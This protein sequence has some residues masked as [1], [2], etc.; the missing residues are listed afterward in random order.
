VK[1]AWRHTC[2]A[3]IAAGLAAAPLAGSRP[4]LAPGAIGVGVAAA[5]LLVGWR[6]R[7]RARATQV[8][9]LACVALAAASAGLGLGSLRIDAIDAGA[10]RAEPGR[11]VEL[12]GVVASPTR[13]EPDGVSA[14]LHTPAGRIQLRARYPD[15]LDVG[16]EATV[17]GRLAEPQ[18]WQRPA[19]ERRGV[20]LAIEAE[21]VAPTGVRRGG[22]AGGIDALRERAESALGRGM[23]ER[24]A[25][26]ARGFVLGQDDAIDP[27]TREDFKRSGLA[28][29]LAVSGQNVILLCL[30]AWPLLALC[31]L[32]L[33]AR[34]LALLALIA[35][36]VR[37]T[38]AGPSI[39]RA[40][41]M[42]AAGLVA[43]LADRPSSRWYA[44]LLAAAVTLALNP[45]AAGD[46]GWQLSF[47]AVLGIFCWTRRLASLLDGGAARASPRRALA[48]G[49]A[50]T[51]AATIATA[52]LMALHFDSVSAS[53]LP[54][55]VLA[56]PAVAPAMWLGMLA[57]M[58]GQLPLVPVE[59]INWLNS[60]CLG[61]VAQV[62]HWLGS[63][64][65]A[66]VEVDLP[67]PL[68]L[69]A[70]SAALAGAVE[71]GLAA[72]RRRAGFARR[73][74]PGPRRRILA[75]AAAAA[76][77]ALAAVAAAGPGGD[78]PGAS[79]EDRLRVVVLDVGQGDSILL[80][81][82]AGAPLLVDTGPSG[83][84]AARRLR[85]LGVDGLG[86]LVV[87]H[88]QSD[89]A[90]AAAEVLASVPA[91]RLALAAPS[92]PLAALAARHGV[93]P[94]PL[95]EGG[96]IRSGELRLSVLWP[97][98]ELAAPERRSGEGDPNHLSLV[99]LA[100]WRHFSM[101]LTG[102]AEAAAA[103]VD[104]GPVD[105][106]KVA[107]HG[108][109]DDGLAGLLDGTA[110]KLAVVSVGENSYGHPA[111]ETL[112]ALSEQDV[113]VARTDADGELVIEA[114]ATGWS[115]DAG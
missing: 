101:L 61:Y 32:T 82:P 104:P 65:W 105:V 52:P 28:H 59:P 110:P 85:E 71:L 108:S 114:D 57:G 2:L 33:R 16:A 19:L 60:L 76:V 113:P 107:H 41:V 13:S 54:A 37:L 43:A 38:G 97:P 40:G 67:G 11:S 69:A 90:G 94:L 102:D 48:E 100:E 91:E 55:N 111:P 58:A 30:L 83:A 84:G 47:A 17:R 31:G 72:A 98:R 22:V 87:T 34:L 3:G 45:R 49:A 78:A 96:E 95:A 63:P 75:P 24:E 53:S 56:Q 68:A 29:L 77:L 26:L 1:R 39:Q 5:A 109:E 7:D 115:L 44:L 20:A 92:E 80:D 46:V 86:A 36:Y 74:P 93:E 81:P 6:P 15:G 18:P 51:I 35:V 106:L 42:G 8:A 9:W 66:L 79:A 21:S 23:P 62:A 10:L 89:H 50:L 14:E 88:D 27:A 73:R 64:G 4:Q 25:A 112:A 12:R 103:P 70:L 99:L